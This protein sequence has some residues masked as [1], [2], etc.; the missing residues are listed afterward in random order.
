ME[1]ETQRVELIWKYVLVEDTDT[2]RSEEEEVDGAA[3][4]QQPEEEL[5]CERE[6]WFFL[7][8]EET[9]R[10]RTQG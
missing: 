4:Q 1:W 2:L 10:V 9:P 8:F 5:S 3:Q 6:M 7:F